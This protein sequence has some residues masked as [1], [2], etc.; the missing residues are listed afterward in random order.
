MKIKIQRSF[1][2][3]VQLKQFEPIE[4]SCAIETEFEIADGKSSDEKKAIVELNSRTIDTLCREEVE[5]TLNQFK[6]IDT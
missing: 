6:S 3:R 4:S 5:K 1:S 2:K